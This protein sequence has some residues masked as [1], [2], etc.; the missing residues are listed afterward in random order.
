LDN[1]DCKP[2]SILNH[3]VAEFFGDAL[4]D[5]LD[6]KSP[7]EAVCQEIQ[8][9]STKVSS[10]MGLNLA[11]QAGTLALASRYSSSDDVYNS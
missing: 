3:V 11:R 1:A 8:D 6:G 5:Q 9:V 10:A 2:K 7:Y 4:R